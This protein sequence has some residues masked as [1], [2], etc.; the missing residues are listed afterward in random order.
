MGYWKNFLG[1]KLALLFFLFTAITAAAPAGA[2]G[3][4]A[5]STY[6]GIV[7]VAAGEFPD[8]HGGQCYPT[9]ATVTPTSLTFQANVGGQN[10]SAQTLR[11][12]D[13][14]GDAVSATVSSKPN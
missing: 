13:N 14:C 9:S 10:P 5:G 2:T 4:Q 8:L 12:I 1:K 7:T 6:T 3:L 11:V